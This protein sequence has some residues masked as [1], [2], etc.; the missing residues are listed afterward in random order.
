M[1]SQIWGSHFGQWI[2]S[3]T[4]LMDEAPSEAQKKTQ[5][6]MNVGTKGG[7]TRKKKKGE[8]FFKW[9]IIA[10]NSNFVEQNVAIT[11]WNPRSIFTKH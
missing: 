10:N 1:D 2:S 11:R 4:D 8:I 6:S 9:P 7:E 3:D 5:P